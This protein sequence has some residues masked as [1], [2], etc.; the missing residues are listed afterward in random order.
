MAGRVDGG[1]MANMAGPRG[2]TPMARSIDAMTI[3]H[4]Q[5]DVE[6]PGGKYGETLPTDV[7]NFTPSTM[8][9][10]YFITDGSSDPPPLPPSVAHCNDSRFP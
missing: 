9:I 7:V 2:S 1:G 6:K 3:A 5:R 8:I 4:D 10:S